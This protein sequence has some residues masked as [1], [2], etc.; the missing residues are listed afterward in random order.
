M[1]RFFIGI[2]LSQ[3]LGKIFRTI[4][5]EIGIQ[6]IPL[7]QLVR[8]PIG[9]IVLT[10]IDMLKAISMSGLTGL[11]VSRFFTLSG[12]RPFMQR[13]QFKLM[14]MVISRRHQFK[15]DLSPGG[16]LTLYTRSLRYDLPTGILA[17]GNERGDVI[18]SF[19][20]GRRISRKM[21]N[22]VANV[23]I[24]SPSLIS[25]CGPLNHVGIFRITNDTL[26]HV[27][28]LHHTNDA[29]CACGHPVLGLIA[30]GSR[31]R[32]LKI[33]SLGPQG[34][35]PC[36]ELREH[37]SH[38]NCVSFHPRLPL[39]ASSSSDGKVNLTLLSHDGSH[40]LSR[41][42][43]EAHYEGKRLK[44]HH[45]GYTPLEWHP[46]PEKTL[47]ISAGNYGWVFIWKLEIGL[48]NEILTED[49]VFYAPSL[50]DS[51]VSSIS[52][53][54]VYPMILLASGAFNLQEL[55]DNVPLLICFSGDFMKVQHIMPLKM[56]G[57]GRGNGTVR[58]V[59]LVDGTICVTYYYSEETVKLRLRM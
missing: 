28:D 18:I 6:S 32:I 9:V 56:S 54:P 23:S 5:G 22:Y 39:L 11:L 30:T 7:Q 24:L 34:A 44:K 51:W 33:W 35:S 50:K 57:I 21:P 4:C 36:L 26:S 52:I 16:I 55:E 49:L 14:M 29:N 58:A 46:D 38:V 27:V 37:E 19:P 43:L 42:M 8:L 3:F 15:F 40:V 41:K 17:I 25:V 20:D 53:H 47:L 13:N 31:D 1:D 10:R 48:S 45:D 2:F 59:F 12:K